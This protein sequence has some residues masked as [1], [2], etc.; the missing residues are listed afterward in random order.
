MTEAG[1]TPAHKR[2]R[3]ERREWQAGDWHCEC[4]A[5]GSHDWMGYAFHLEQ[6]V[7]AALRGAGDTPVQEPL[8]TWPEAFPGNVEVL[9]NAIETHW[10]GRGRGKFTKA[11]AVL[12]A[13]SGVPAPAQEQLR[14]YAPIYLD[15]GGDPTFKQIDAFLQAHFGARAVRAALSERPRSVRW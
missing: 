14:D 7:L 12:A 1:D 11:Y 5:F 2:I 13:L 10:R 6:D 4:G 15:G 9:A 8:R 3:E